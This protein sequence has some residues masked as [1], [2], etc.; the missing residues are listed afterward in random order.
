[1][2][3]SVCCLSIK[4]AIYVS[5]IDEFV[6]AVIDM[7]GSTE[8]S[9]SSETEEVPKREILHV[10]RQ[11]LQ[12]KNDYT[13]QFP[14]ASSVHFQT[15]QWTSSPSHLREGSLAWE[16]AASPMI[17]A[18]EKQALNAL[19]LHLLGEP[20]TPTPSAHTVSLGRTNTQETIVGN[21]GS[22]SCEQ[23]CCLQKAPKDLVEF[24]H[25]YLPNTQDRDICWDPMVENCTNETGTPTV[26]SRGSYV[27]LV[28][29][30]RIASQPHFLE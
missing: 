10:D 9:S 22:H 24:R 27:D 21:A 2:C 3:S 4:F 6:S 16:R 14:S 20:I 1:M 13:R 12:S 26:A 28:Y 29:L 17:Q 8:C 25:G 11:I 18:S 5:V 15:N 23:P 19:S 7:R 30:P